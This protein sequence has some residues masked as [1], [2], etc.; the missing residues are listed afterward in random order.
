MKGL[1]V[2]FSILTICVYIISYLSYFNWVFELFSNFRMYY[3]YISLLFVITHLYFKQRYLLS[4]HLVFI[5][6]IILEIAPFL[7]V[8]SQLSS[9][10]DIKIISANILSQNNEKQLVLDWLVHEDADVVFLM[11]I[12]PEWDESLGKL[13]SIYP[14]HLTVPRLDN[15]GLALYSKVPLN[16]SRILERP[17]QRI[18]SIITKLKF[19]HQEYTFIGAHPEPPLGPM[20][21]KERNK[22]LERLN[23]LV[24]IYPGPTIIAGDFNCSSFSWNLKRLTQNTNLKDS[25]LGKGLQNS[26]SATLPF[27]RFAIDHCFVTD[28]IQISSRNIGPANGSDH[29][30][31]ILHIKK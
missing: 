7:S 1:V 28:D 14:H 11:E 24:H 8:G 12:T 6:A 21:F 30:P 23:E 16:E 10:N 5:I 13:D 19:E 3:L 26:W 29:Y 27:F 17:F 20:S 15:F 22:H 18:P 2:S 4:I 31:I 9:N 25:R